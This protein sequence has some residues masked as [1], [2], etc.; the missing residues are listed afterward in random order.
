MKYVKTLKKNPV[1]KFHFQAFFKYQRKFV[2][3]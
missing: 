3:Q 2:A 1:V